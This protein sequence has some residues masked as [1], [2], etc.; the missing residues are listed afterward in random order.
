MGAAVL[1]AS[2]VAMF[3][4]MPAFTPF[5][6]VTCHP[7]PPSQSITA[8]QSPSATPPTQSTPEVSTECY[9]TLNGAYPLVFLLSVAGTVAM[10]YGLLGRDF[11]VNPVSVVGF[12]ALE[13]GLAAMTSASLN[14]KGGVS[15]SPLI[16]FPYVAIGAL[17]LCIQAYRRTLRQPSQSP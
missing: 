1:C 7:I 11:I 17:V 10:L 14:T 2:Y 5:Q 15:E 12:I 3:V 16:F 6:F 13:W 9:T 8:I 4:A